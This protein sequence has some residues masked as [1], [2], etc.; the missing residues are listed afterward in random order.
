MT[1]TRLGLVLCLWAAAMA[2]VPQPGKALRLVE[3]E[4]RV[5][6]RIYEMYTAEGISIGG[7]TRRIKRRWHS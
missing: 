6:Q 2:R 3:E 7:I 4:A 5:A 1:N